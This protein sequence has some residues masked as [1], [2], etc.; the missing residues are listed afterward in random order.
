MQKELP[1]VDDELTRVSGNIG[2]AIQA[3]FQRW[4]KGCEFRMNELH[5]A[6]LREHPGVAPGSVDRVMRMMRRQGAVGYE[7]VS[8]R[9]SLYRITAC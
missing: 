6:V 8:R 2:P 7:L 5:A 4:G 3:A 9:G 1:F